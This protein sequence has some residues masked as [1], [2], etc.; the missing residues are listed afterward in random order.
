VEK[1][2]RW[3]SGWAPQRPKQVSGQIGGPNS[4]INSDIRA[5]NLR[6]R[7]TDRSREK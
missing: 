4:F 5:G 3:T 7:Q 1:Y 6:G 2:D